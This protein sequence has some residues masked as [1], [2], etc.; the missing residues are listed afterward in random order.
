MHYYYNTVYLGA[1]S[2][3]RQVL[4]QQRATST[5]EA[6]SLAQVARRRQR[7]N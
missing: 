5:S 6:R 4:A 7:F 2:Y 3:R 1:Q